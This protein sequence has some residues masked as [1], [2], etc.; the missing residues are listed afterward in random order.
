MSENIDKDILLKAV[1]MTI[2]ELF[3]HNQKYFVL[4]DNTDNNH[5]HVTIGKT[6]YDSKNHTRLHIDKKKLVKIKKIKMVLQRLLRL[7]V[8]LLKLN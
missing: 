5:V 2:K 6:S 4:H 8:I 3:P 1:Q 7:I